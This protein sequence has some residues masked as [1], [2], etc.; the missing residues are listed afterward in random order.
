MPLELECN[1]L[2]AHA[3]CSFSPAP[4]NVTEQV[5]G[6]TTVTIK[7]NV[8]VGTVIASNR[9]SSW[10]FGAALAAGLAGLVFAGKTKRNGR[11]LM[12]VCSAL[13]I[14]GMAAGIAG[15]GNSSNT[16][17]TPQ[18]TTP[19]GTYTVIV[20]AKQIGNQ[21]VTLPNGTTVHYSGSQNLISLPFTINV[22]VQ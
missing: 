18:L 9:I 10:S 4:V 17:P 19:A 15:C 3:T 22:T 8:P 2:P 5:P 11:V 20:T 7:T 14:T 16:G 21:D 13:L 6:T 1:N 12:M